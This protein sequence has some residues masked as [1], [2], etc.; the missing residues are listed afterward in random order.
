MT[1]EQEAFLALFNHCFRCP[2]CQPTWVGDT[3]VHR[4][5]PVAEDLYGQWRETLKRK[6]AAL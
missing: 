2:D 1:A 6:A 4:D 3:P 5:C